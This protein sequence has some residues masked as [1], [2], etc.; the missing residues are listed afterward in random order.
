MDIKSLSREEKLE[1]LAAIEEKRR[2]AIASKPKYM[3]N[4]G[5]APIH[6]SDAK[7]RYVFSANGTGKSALLVQELHA[8]ATGYNPWSASKTKA[9]SKICVVVDNSKKIDEVIMPEYRKWFDVDEKWLKREGKPYTSKIH[10]PNGSVVTF[11]SAEADPMTFEGVMFDYVFIDEPLPQMLYT[12]IKRGLRIK[13]SPSR[14]LFCGT[15]VSQPWLKTLIWDKWSNGE[16]TDV[17]CFRVGI[18]VNEHNLGDGYVKRFS[19]TMSESE[20]EVRLRGGFFN[21]DGMALAHLWKR[22]VHLVSRKDLQW[23]PSWPCVIG[24][25]PHPVKKHNAVLLGVDPND[26]LVVLDELAI[27]CTASEFAEHLK[28]LMAGHNVIDIVCDSLGSMDTTSAEGFDSFIQVLNDR[29]LKVRATRYAD[30]SHE[31]LVD[32]LQSG[33]LIPEKD[34]FGQSIPKLRVA[35]HCTG[36]I[37]DIESVGWQRNKMTGEYRPKLDTSAKDYLSALGYALA[38]DLFYSKPQRMRPSML[39]KS[40]YRGIDIVQRRSAKMSIRRN[41]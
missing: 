14:L 37:N 23:D 30:K 13:G 10:Y 1:L 16:T 5:Q 40:P 7:E 18:E 39:T 34:N 27:K 19:A 38:T 28:R 12:A 22:S 35:G 15:A 3:P 24:I 33:L 32:R 20:K 36:I 29:G 26:R 4:K 8:A 17:E 2:R 6:K 41:R 31:D 11:Y 21:S 9:P 25:D